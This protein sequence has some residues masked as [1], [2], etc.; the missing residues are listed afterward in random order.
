MARHA[1]AVTQQGRA[2]KLSVK[3]SKGDATWM[4]DIRPMS[5]RIDGEPCKMHVALVAAAQGRKVRVLK[6]GIRRITYG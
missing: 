6:S 3:Q 2:W 1:G 5:G 4:N